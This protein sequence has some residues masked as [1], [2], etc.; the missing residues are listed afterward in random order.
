MM[1]CRAQFGSPLLRGILLSSISMLNAFQSYVGAALPKNNN[2]DVFLCA[3]SCA[4]TCNFT[5][6]FPSFDHSH[7]L[8]V[9]LAPVIDRKHSLKSNSTRWCEGS[10]I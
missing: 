4:N 3:S 9:P 5:A 1:Q 2:E 6:M 8:D 10:G 7:S